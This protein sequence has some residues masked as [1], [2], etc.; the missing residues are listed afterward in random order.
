V[1]RF[2][3]RVLVPCY[4]EGMGTITATINAALSAPLPPGVRRTLYLCDDGKDPNKKRWLEQA[5]PMDAVYV[6]GRTRAPAEI[7]GKS[8]NLNN[9]T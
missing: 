2:H 4:K 5:Y 3:V 9:C 8:A 1:R 7:N 6:S